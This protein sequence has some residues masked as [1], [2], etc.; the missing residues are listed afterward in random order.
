MT[1]IDLAAVGAVDAERVR[2]CSPGE[3]G[4]P[5]HPFAPVARTL[6]CE[7]EAESE[8]DRGCGTTAASACSANDATRNKIR[9]AKSSVGEGRE[10]F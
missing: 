6:E 2:L 7:A 9:T 1:S 8:T 5:P 4:S 10:I 3:R